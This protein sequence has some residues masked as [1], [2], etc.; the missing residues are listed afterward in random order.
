LS[1]CGTGDDA[2]GALPATAPD[3]DPGLAHVHGLGVNPAD[4]RVYVATHFGLWRLD[5]PG[6]AQRVGDYFYDLMGFTVVGEDHF[7]ASGHP[8]LTDDLPP[9]LG[10]IETTDAG[11]TWHSVSLLGQV[12]FHAL[13]A[14]HGFVYGWNS[15]DGSFMV[16]DDRQE[17]ER[18]STHSAMVDFV[19]DPDDPD[20]LLAS[21]AESF[22][23]TGLLRSRDGGAS[24]T[25]V[26]DPAA[27]VQLA[28]T[29]PDRLWGV[30]IDGSVWHSADAGDTWEQTG[31][32]AGRPEALLDTGDA[33]VV[34]GGGLIAESADGGQTWAELF[35][36]D[37][38]T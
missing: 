9:L 12:D 36:E 4:G 18:R 11:Q 32:A 25:P 10:L 3:E 8:L 38:H 31:Q 24:W 2:A 20:H 26:D 13:R 30:A 15:T 17:W 22:E 34:A 5:G 1:A 35:R 27:I 19:V 16:S 37:D 21:I 14:A 6:Q 29:A 33:L 7:L 28:W 23:E